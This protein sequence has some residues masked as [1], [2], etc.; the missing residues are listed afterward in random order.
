MKYAHNE[1]DGRGNNIVL[2]GISNRSLIQYKQ[3]S[4]RNGSF[5]LQL[6]QDN[7][8]DTS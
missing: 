1:F 8:I 7:L 4:R 2:Y 5:Q 6:I 3:N